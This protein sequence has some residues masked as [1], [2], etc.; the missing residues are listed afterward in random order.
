MRLRLVVALLF[1]ISEL[2]Y[3]KECS[4]FV[5][6]ASDS[7]SI[8]LWTLNNNTCVDTLVG[9]RH[10]VLVIEVYDYGKMLASGSLDGIVK[11]WS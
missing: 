11:L 1:P 7:Y 10:H 4:L 8:R 2:T 3:G 6:S 9:H 5:A